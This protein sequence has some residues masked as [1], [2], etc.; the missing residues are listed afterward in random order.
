MKLLPKMQKISHRGKEEIHPTWY[1]DTHIKPI[2]CCGRDPDLYGGA[3]IKG[4]LKQSVYEFRC[5]L[6]GRNGGEYILPN[7]AACSWNNSFKQKQGQG[8]TP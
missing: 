3:I 4:F 8:R 5:P 2:A 6:C 1:Y 7:G